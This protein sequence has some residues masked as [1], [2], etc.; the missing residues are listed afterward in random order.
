MGGTPHNLI[1][2][3]DLTSQTDGS[4]KTFTVPTFRHAILLICPDF[5]IVYRPT[6]DYTLGNKTI[7]LTSSVDAPSSGQT[8]I[9]LYVK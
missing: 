1:Q 6:T 9:L 4:T 3:E 2:A 7:T 8:L 5:P